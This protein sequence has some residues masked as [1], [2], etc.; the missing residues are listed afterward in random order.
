ML[1]QNIAYFDNLISIR[2]FTEAAGSLNG[3]PLYTISR[4][5]FNETL[6]KFFDFLLRILHKYIQFFNYCSCDPRNSRIFIFINL[7][8]YVVINSENYARPNYI[9]I[10]MTRLFIILFKIY[11]PIY[12]FRIIW[13]FIIFYVDSSETFIF[14]LKLIYKGF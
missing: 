9:D 1:L 2:K 3:S 11:I 12:K 5:I 7:L 14:I 10:K 6:I 4:I 8:N 13:N